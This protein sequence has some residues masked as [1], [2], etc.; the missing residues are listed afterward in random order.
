[1]WALFLISVH[2]EKR[3]YNAILSNDFAPVAQPGRSPLPEKEE[4]ERNND[5]YATYAI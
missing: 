3:N 1:M 2:Y 4:I 5:I